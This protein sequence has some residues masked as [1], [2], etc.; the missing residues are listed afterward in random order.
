ME[1]HMPKENKRYNLNLPQELFDEIEQKS[2]DKDISVA[3]L[4]RRLLKLGLDALEDNVKLVIVDYDNDSEKEVKI[5][6]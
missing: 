3:H 2:K 5:L 1:G 6:W 4:M